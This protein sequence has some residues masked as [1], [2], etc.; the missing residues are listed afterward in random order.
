MLSLFDVALLMLFVAAAAWLWRGHGI[1][2]QALL[3]ARRH[4]EKIDI[5]LLDENVALQGLRLLR[6]RQGRRRLAREYNF[7]FTVT[8]DQRLHGRITLFGRQL[9]SIELD[10]HPFS[11]RDEDVLPSAQ[12]IQLADWRREHARS[13]QTPQ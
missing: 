12:V 4:C 6:D 8:G 1:R 3:L 10:P 13:G 2:E 9:A 11:A 7:E 5:E